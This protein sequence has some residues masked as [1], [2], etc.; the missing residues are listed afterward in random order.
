[1]AP[2]PFLIARCA[3]LGARLASLVSCAG[4]ASASS[5]E[6]S[7][8]VPHARAQLSITVGGI[9]TFVANCQDLVDVFWALRA[10]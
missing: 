10:P 8:S 3:V 5:G 7:L 4:G 2:N 6:P 1:M 9:H